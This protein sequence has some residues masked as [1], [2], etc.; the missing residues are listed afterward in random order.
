MLNF[1]DLNLIIRLDLRTP[2]FLWI[3]NDFRCFSFYF[4]FFD[5]SKH[6]V[7]INHLLLFFL[8]F[9]CLAWWWS[10]DSINIIKTGFKMSGSI[11]LIFGVF[12]KLNLFWW[13][14][15]NFFN[16]FVYY[17]FKS[18]NWDRLGRFFN[19]SC[20]ILTVH[21]EFFWILSLILM[22]L[23]LS[24]ILTCHI[25]HSNRLWNWKYT[26][27]RL[28]HLT[29]WSSSRPYSLTWWPPRK[30]VLWSS[31]YLSGFTPK[32]TWSGP[33]RWGESFFAI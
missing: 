17:W 26:T 33:C 27:M 11:Q 4:L 28:K 25:L 21:I 31:R 12:Y 19:D 24:W 14:A 7:C 8:K 2:V 22:I 18:H 23:V 20:R 10:H 29:G 30:C 6:I 32:C 13:L 9:F 15:N 5:S 1:D 3:N 16:F